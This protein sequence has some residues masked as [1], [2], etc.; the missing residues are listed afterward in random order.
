MIRRPATSGCAAKSSGFRSCQRIPHGC[1]RIA[2][3]RTTSR[4]P[5]WSSGCALNY[6]KMELGLSG[7]L[8]ST[9]A[10][11]VAARAMDREGRP[12]SDI[13]AFY[14]GATGGVRLVGALSPHNDV[15]R[16]AEPVG[17]PAKELRNRGVD[18]G[19]LRLLARIPPPESTRLFQLRPRRRDAIEVCDVEEIPFLLSSQV[20]RSCRG[21]RTSVRSPPVSTSRLRSGSSA[22]V[23]RQWVSRGRWDE[24]SGGCRAAGSTSLR[25]RRADVPALDPDPGA[26]A[27]RLVRGAEALGGPPRSITTGFDRWADALR[28]A[29][30]LAGTI[31]RDA[32]VDQ[33]IAEEAPRGRQSVSSSVRPSSGPSATKSPCSAHLRKSGSAPRNSYHSPDRA[34]T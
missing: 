4:C 20:F 30:L 11:I 21:R 26:R 32:V 6:P 5:V 16:R 14:T 22:T 34:R 13:L 12:R 15:D 9:H 33:G 3:R 29:R 8:D 2:T 28:R 31:A 17:V 27:D 1:N 18:L 10:L 24:R 19:R 7:G 25:R 23:P